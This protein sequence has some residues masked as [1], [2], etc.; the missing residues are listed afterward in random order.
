MDSRGWL[1]GP[2][3][4]EGTRVWFGHRRKEMNKIKKGFLSKP[5]M[6]VYRN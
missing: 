6:K 2:V 1:W 5:I 3:R 4:K